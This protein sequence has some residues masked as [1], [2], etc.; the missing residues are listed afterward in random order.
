M[1]LAY[2]LI[3]QLSPERRPAFED[4]LYST[5]ILAIQ[6]IA[7]L[8]M[9]QLARFPPASAWL[10]DDAWAHL[11]QCSPPWPEVWVEWRT[12]N[13]LLHF[14]RDPGPSLQNAPSLGAAVIR[15]S[16]L[17][18]DYQDDPPTIAPQYRLDLHCLSSHIP[19][20]SAGS[21]SLFLSPQGQLCHSQNPPCRIW[22]THSL[23]DAYLDYLH[24]APQ[25]R[26]LRQRSH[27]NTLT[28]H[29]TTLFDITWVSPV[30]LAFSYFNRSQVFVTHELVSP[31]HLPDTPR[32]TI[33]T[34]SVFTFHLPQGN[35][36][37]N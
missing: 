20:A 37:T 35:P 29:A 26:P 3:K 31:P 8:S 18:D 24:T 25:L 32:E 19:G 7:N 11:T 23:S 15:L 6:D 27:P 16:A 34:T 21:A 10:P 13:T 2:D 4:A 5:G 30:L 33:P 17:S 9:E 12:P 28:G 22:I 36:V 14:S 1:L